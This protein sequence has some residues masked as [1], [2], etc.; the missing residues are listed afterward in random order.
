MVIGSVIGSAIGS[1]SR[2]SQRS[3]SS[4]P[5]EA[6]H[7]ARTVEL[8]YQRKLVIHRL[9]YQVVLEP[10]TSPNH[11]LSG[12]VWSGRFACLCRYL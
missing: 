1:R 10:K 5:L 4:N 2:F 9:V 8:R 3:A 11:G 7:P 12:M 6:I